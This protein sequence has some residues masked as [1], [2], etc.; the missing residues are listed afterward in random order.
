MPPDMLKPYG[1]GVG[2]AGF[3]AS[4]PAIPQLYWDVYSAEQRWKEICCNLKKL[5]EYADS[6]NIELGVT[7]NRVSK[8][9]A[10]FQKF[11]ESGY[12]DYYAKQIEQWILDNT[13]WIFERFCK[14]VFFGLTDD[15]YFCAY[16]PDSWKE[17]TFDTGMNYGT[18][19][20]GRL[21]LRYDTDGSGVIDNTEYGTPGSVEELNELKEKVAKLQ[22]TVYTALSK[23]G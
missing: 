19:T 4:T 3:T 16:V 17:I 1:I 12:F 8:L 21:I 7:K 18:Y 9:E 14:M 5:I 22:Q 20:Y 23:E 10:D 15:G 13:A 2:F 11:L 6:M